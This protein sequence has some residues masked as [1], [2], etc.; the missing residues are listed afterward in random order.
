M[1]LVITEKPSVAK[2]ISAVLGAD[3]R[4]DGYLENENYLVSW[5]FG[6]LA[7]LASAE[8]YDEAY[9]KWSREQL[10]IIPENWQYSVG[11]DKKKQLDLLTELMRRADVMEIINACDA[12]REGELIFRTVY[13]LAGCVKPVKRLWISSME[14]AAIREGFDNL[15]DGSEYD[16]LY[17]AA[18]CRSKADWLVGINATR[19]FSV[20]YHRT[21]NV[22]RVVSPTL[23]L[24]VQREA[25]IKAFQPEP[26]YTVKLDTG[27]FTAASEKLK[28]KQD[29]ENLK[30]ACTGTTAVIR[31]V[32]QKEKSE[33]APAL[34]D[35]TTLQRDANRILGFTAQ[36]TLDYLQS[37][38]EKKLCTYPR[39]DSRFLTDDME[40]GVPAVAACAAGILGVS[41]GEVSAKQVCDSRRVSDHHAVIPT[42]AAGEAELSAL[43]AGER[44]VLKLV[45]RQV[46]MAVSAP[47][48]YLETVVTIDCGG[49]SFTAKGK[50]VLNPGWKSYAAGEQKEKV[51]PPL[52]EGQLIEQFEVSLEEGK[53]K[54]PARYTED[55]LLSAMENAGSREMPA[56][57]VCFDV[58]RK[59]LGTP[60]TRAG[61]LEKLV[62]SGFVERKKNKKAVSLIPQDI[63]ISLITVL[64]EQLQSPLLT[65]EWENMLKEIEHGELSPDTFMAQINR[66]VSDLV[67]DY[68]PVGGAEVL[69]PSGRPVVGK[70]PRCGGSV[71]ESKAG[72]FCER[73]ECRFGLWKDN[74]YLSAKH[75][76]LTKKMAEALL[77]DGKTFVSGMYS[78]K[79]GRSYS[80]YLVLTDDGQKSSYALEFDKEKTDA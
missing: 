72:F 21:L 65:A 80:A 34:Y 49:Q 39:T 20:L 51:L 62:S 22:G 68:E 77:K 37:L 73:R 30:S 25:E 59:G 15:R 4:R 56:N 41:V 8:V 67:R 23:A 69:F 26:F 9:A 18:I 75:I 28:N 48:S 43:T 33:K 55:T 70:C 50:T 31:S 40:S 54:P 64:P 17:A 13:L 1:K 2:S 74:R 35:L 63:G 6:H 3:K 14:D 76:I 36:Q 66:M 12:G 60:A 29:A 52:I 45:A 19:L 61:I 10:P 42:M 47:Y 11:R 53:T 32:E 44:E 38:Y 57:E 24:L 71:T 5:C 7:E 79:S 27:D 58:E 16:K 46:L 78:E